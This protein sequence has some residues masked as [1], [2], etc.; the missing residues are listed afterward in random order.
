M[1]GKVLDVYIT[2]SKLSGAGG[3]RTARVSLVP[4]WRKWPSPGDAPIEA[5]E[6]CLWAQRRRGEEE[7]RG[8][9]RKLEAEWSVTLKMRKERG[10]VEE[11]GD[12]EW[13]S[14]RGASIRGPLRL[15]IW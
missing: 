9:T 15:A 13:S 14:R 11:P 5:G 4:R 8:V 7:L 1:A 12:V 3:M 6:R 10:Q 2:S